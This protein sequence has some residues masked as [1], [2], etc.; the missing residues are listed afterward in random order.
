MF[1][2]KLEELES[3]GASGE[4]GPSGEPGCS[5]ALVLAALN[6]FIGI[7]DHRVAH[8]AQQLVI[9]LAEDA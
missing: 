8:D 7:R 5:S 3:S 4:A 9:M 1:R 6:F 2:D